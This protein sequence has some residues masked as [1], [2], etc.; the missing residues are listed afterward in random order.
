[1][2]AEKIFYTLKER[3]L[4]RDTEGNFIIDDAKAALQ[5]YQ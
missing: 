5:N 4:K 3:F 1:M 2:T